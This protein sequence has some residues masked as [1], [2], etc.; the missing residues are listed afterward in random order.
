MQCKQVA[1][2]IP[3]FICVRLNCVD[4][5]ARSGSLPPPPPPPQQPLPPWQHRLVSSH[6][7]LHIWS[8][9][10]GNRDE[11]SCCC[12]STR[13]ATQDPSS[14]NPRRL[15]VECLGTSH[16][17]SFHVSIIH[18]IPRYKLV[19]LEI[20][21]K[22]FIS[23]SQRGYTTWSVLHSL[24]FLNNKRVLQGGLLGINNYC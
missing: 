1:P 16:F 6:R 15:A 24:F 20:I 13:I 14:A 12:G 8:S 21:S 11:S 19:F 10:G 17:T 3:L 4:A 9:G 5:T 18:T 23:S 2:F 22:L 7:A